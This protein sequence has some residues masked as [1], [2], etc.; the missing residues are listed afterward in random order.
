MLAAQKGIMPS[1]ELKRQSFLLS[2]IRGIPTIPVDIS[3]G[4]ILQTVQRDNKKVGKDIAF[5]LMDSI[6]SVHRTGS[7]I[8]TP[9]TPSELNP[10]LAEYWDAVL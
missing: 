1:Q 5:I 7:S 9:V 4:Q 6:G 8:L 2:Q 10:V 3:I